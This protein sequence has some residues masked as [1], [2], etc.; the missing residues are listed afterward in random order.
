MFAGPNGSGKSALINYLNDDGLPLNPVVNADILLQR[1]HAEGY[2]DLDSF[3]LKGI[4]QK[5]WR[6]SISNIDEISSRISKWPQ[7][8]E[9]EIVDE[10]LLCKDKY[11]N[12]Y[13]AAFIADFIRY[14]L[15]K[16]EIGFSFET[17]MSHPGK[18]GFLTKAKQKGFKVYLYYLATDNAQVNVERVKRRV[19]QG[20]HSVPEK[21]VRKRYKRSLQL[22]HEAYQTSD[23]VFIMDTSGTNSR[24]LYEKK[25][26]GRGYNRSDE[27]PRWFKEYFLNKLDNV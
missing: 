7:I 10:I 23:R 26:N 9:I 17:V 25:H 5:D 27:S 2:I 16:Q 24:V 14:M 21:K 19:R 8:P 22:L 1:L 3:H 15:L 4:T 13:T 6:E 18:I 12:A 11:V 20:G